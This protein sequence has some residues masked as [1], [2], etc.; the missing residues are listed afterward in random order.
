MPINAADTVWV[1]VSAA[2]VM[3]MTPE[4]LFSTVDGTPQE[5]SLNTYDVFRHVGLIGLLWVIYGYS[6][7]FGPD[8]WGII[9]G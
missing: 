1:L 3:I 6:L 5:L 9:A 8:K 7:S 2:M 4:L